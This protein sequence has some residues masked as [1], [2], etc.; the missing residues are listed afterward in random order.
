MWILTLFLILIG[1][2]SAFVGYSEWFTIDRLNKSNVLNG[3]LL[4][5]T[6]FTLL[7]IAFVMGYFPQNFAAPLMMG[8]YS[9]IAGFFLG[10]SYRLIVLRK[11]AA[12]GLY[13]HRSFLVD[14]APNLLAVVLVIY[15]VF[16]TAILSDQAV[17]GI[18]LSSGI[19]LMSF[20][21]FIWTLNAVPE[22]RSNGIILLDRFIHWRNVISWRWDSES[23]IMIEFILEDS[24]GEEKLS[25]FVTSIPEDEK[26]EIEIVLK[27][28]LEEFEEYRKEKMFKNNN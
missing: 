26:K 25:Q 8:I 24:K 15:G 6:V 12:H 23:S 4:V 2:A 7:M 11:K 18:R 9:A 10:Y 17:T 27:S 1:L 28:K 14:H 16:R 13:Q 20:G 19:S 22:F 3:T 5:L 21:A